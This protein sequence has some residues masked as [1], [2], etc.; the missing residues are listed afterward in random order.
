MFNIEHPEYART[1]FCLFVLILPQPSTMPCSVERFLD[2][3]LCSQVNPIDV[4]DKSKKTLVKYF[5]P[6]KFYY[7]TYFVSLQSTGEN[8]AEIK[9]VFS[10]EKFELS[11]SPR[12]I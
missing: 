1:F 9:T 6:R 11:F 8:N 7:R 4:L 5:E 3:S 12:I 2:F 10:I